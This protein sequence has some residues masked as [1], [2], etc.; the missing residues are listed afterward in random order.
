ML[1]IKLLFNTISSWKVEVSN[2]V[3]GFTPLGGEAGWINQVVDSVGGVDKE[4]FEALHFC[5]HVLTPGNLSLQH[6]LFWI[7][8]EQ[9]WTFCQQEHSSTTPETFLL[10]Q[11]ALFQDQITLNKGVIL[12]V[13]LLYLQQSVSLII[14]EVTNVS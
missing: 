9:S 4:Y 8:I 7:N 10:V 5:S 14:T 6:F 1:E 13:S 11:D 3:N 2:T 12:V